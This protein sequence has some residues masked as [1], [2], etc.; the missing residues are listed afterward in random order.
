MRRRTRRTVPFAHGQ[1][2]SDSQGIMA[3]FIADPR[4]F[5]RIGLCSLGK[6]VCVLGSGVL[7]HRER[8]GRRGALPRSGDIKPG[9]VG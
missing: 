5:L 1:V 9:A 3:M 4:Y 2:T 6:A 7:A 8:P